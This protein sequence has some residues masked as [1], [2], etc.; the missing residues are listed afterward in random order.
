MIEEPR[1][2]VPH[3]VAG[4]RPGED[5][6]ATSSAYYEFQYGW[7]ARHAL[8]MT[9]PSSELKWILCEWHTDFIL[10]WAESF[11]PVS[12]KHREPNSG[13]WTVATMFSDGGLDTLYRRWDE[14]G[15][16]AQGRWVTNGGLDSECQALAKACS[17]SDTSAL[18]KLGGL[19]SGVCLEF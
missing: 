9:D 8:E 6:G 15:R 3:S 14:L 13:R 16:P 7:V 5:A 18:A 1:G 11:T 17:E 10:G 19:N 4:K 2:A 12:V